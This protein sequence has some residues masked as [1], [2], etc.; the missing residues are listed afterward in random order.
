M[1]ISVIYTMCP[2]S[3]YIDNLSSLPDPQNP[4]HN[5]LLI[6]QVSREVVGDLELGG[7]GVQVRDHGQPRSA[8]LIV[9]DGRDD[10]HRK[11]LRS[12]RVVHLH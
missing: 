12:C 7:L 10:V 11:R 5:L 1:H 4:L 6:G 2:G 9:Y 8:C 3:R